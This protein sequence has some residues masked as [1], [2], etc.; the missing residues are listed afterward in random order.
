V[1]LGA[2]VLNALGAAL[3][4]GAQESWIAD[5]LDHDAMTHV[6]I[7]AEQ[8]SLVGVIIG[9]VGAAFLASASL[10]LPLLVGGAAMGLLAIVLGLVMPERN[11][12]PAATGM[13]LRA[14]VTAGTA[15]AA[16]QLRSTNRVVRAIPGLVLIFGMTFFVGMW[17]ESFDRLW[18]AFLLRDIAFPH[19]FGATP[20]VWFSVLACAVAVLAIGTTEI[21]G[22]RTKRLGPSSVT[23]TLLVVTGLMVAAVVVLGTAHA[24]AVAAIAYLV[25]SALRPAYEPLITGWMV[26]RVDS[27]VR[28]TALSARDMVDSGGQIVG[29][30]IIGVIGNLASIRAALLAGAVALGPAMGLL[31]LA[32]RRVRAVYN[33]PLEAGIEDDDDPNPP[34]TLT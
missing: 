19:L 24:F 2:Q 11:F 18:G 32:G 17:S 12:T 27:G 20:V 14:F 26:V 3:M 28:A 7:R 22:R 25:V 23:G 9:S 21:A 8:I 6:Y 10:R 1:F 15:M 13:S 29:G 16:V 33:T 5:E 4:Y 34:P 30:P 31:A